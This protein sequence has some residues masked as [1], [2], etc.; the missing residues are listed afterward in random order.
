MTRIA[1]LDDYQ[2]VA[3]EFC[4]WSRVPG[5]VDVVEFHEHLGDED[6]VAAALQGFDV[7][8][9]MRERTEFRRGL[10]ERLPDLRLL[11]T[12]GMRNKSI[13]VEAA[14]ERGITVCGTGS[15]ATAT[16]ELTWA[17]I[18]GAA[19]HV[20]QEDA[21][22]RAGGWQQTI[23]TD[24]AGARLGVIGLGRLGSR[25]ATI[26]QAFGMDVVAWSQNLTDERAAEVGVHRVE[27][28]ELFATSDVVTVHLLLSKRTRGLIGAD[29]L[30]LMMHNA[31]LVNTS[32]GPIVQQQPLI[33]AL[34]DGRIACAALD[35]YDE[36]PLPADHPLRTTPRT[37][38]T[39]HLG[40][41]TRGTYEVFYGE[42]V[43]DVA[44]WAAG[45]PVRVLAP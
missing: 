31:V 28:E 22:M 25:V 20:A 16:V 24:L 5:E 3:A 11:V 2:S 43:E 10:L 7:V 17:L 34:T 35:V 27:R 18:L 45:S 36:E 29:D 1:V 4:D 37:L 26:G 44:A 6:A 15:N 32:R 30:A 9:A 38:L 42:A 14:A 40:Y 8:V 21:G 41:V 33:D 13:D 19:R 39:P 23:G 12:T